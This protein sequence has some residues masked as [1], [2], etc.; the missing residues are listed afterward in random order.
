M[1]ISSAHSYGRTRE[2]LLEVSAC[3]A[4]AME[5]GVNFKAG[6]A[7][8]LADRP[9]TR[10]L[11][12]HIIGRYHEAH[13]R[14]LPILIGLS[15]KVES[16]HRGHPQMPANLS[17]ILQ[18]ML[19]ELEMHMCKEE[20]IVFALI[21]EGQG[22]LIGNAIDMMM[23]DHEDHSTMLRELRALTSDCQPPADACDDWRRLYTGL[24]KLIDDLVAHIQL[25]NNVLFPRF[26]DK[27][28]AE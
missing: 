8:I 24:R 7:M 13:R 23:T 6:L 18:T 19:L 1:S 26:I 20:H 11:I 21:M 22:P 10:D 28:A 2:L 27:S 12:G 5:S 25:E 3:E 4:S 16:R 17:R 15:D 14:E 9:K